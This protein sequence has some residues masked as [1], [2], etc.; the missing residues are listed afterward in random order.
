MG[1][2]GSGAGRLGLP[3]KGAFKGDYMTNVDINNDGFMDII[4]CKKGTSSST[5]ADNNSY[6]LVTN[7]VDSTFTFNSSFN[8]DANG[9]QKGAIAV[10]DFDKDGDFDFIWHCLI[11]GRVHRLPILSREA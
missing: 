4:A 5:D 3:E 9:G 1:S 7:D 6:D 11:E 2:G 10:A 8:E